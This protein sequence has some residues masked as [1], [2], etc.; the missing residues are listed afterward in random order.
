M[1]QRNG[2]NLLQSSVAATI[3]AGKVNIVIFTK[4]AFYFQCF[5]I[6]LPSASP[7]ASNLPTRFIPKIENV[8]NMA[9]VSNGKFA[10][11]AGDSSQPKVA[12]TQ[13]VLSLGAA[14]N[15]LLDRVVVQQT[16]NRTFQ[17]KCTYM[18]N[19]GK[20]NVTFRVEEEIWRTFREKA[21]ASGS[22]AS[23][24]LRQFMQE[25]IKEDQEPTPELLEPIPEISQEPPQTVI[26]W[27]VND[28]FE[29]IDER[30]GWIKAIN[31]TT[32]SCMVLSPYI[33]L[34]VLQLAD[35]VEKVIAA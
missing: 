1:I 23:K 5:N 26:E 24:T 20:S 9:Q 6:P 4:T 2:T 35:L 12:H 13:R 10:D 33:R 21:E 22:T 29:D 11:L 17:A 34:E 30:R 31:G 19:Q 14:L 32:A 27:A 7:D 15:A 18:K 28:W 16:K 8:S 3:E 25:F